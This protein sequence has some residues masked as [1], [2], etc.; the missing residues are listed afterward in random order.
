MID[1]HNHILPGI[2]DGAKTI[3]D[4]FA[5]LKEAKEAGFTKIIFTPHY[6]E[7]FYEVE[8]PEKIAL[9][10]EIKAQFA[11]IEPEME[12][13]LANEIYMSGDNIIEYLEQAKASTINNTRYVLFELPM[14][15]KP[16]NLF[17]MV[18]EIQRAKLIPVL[19]HPE[20]YSFVQNNPDL[21]YDLIERGI[22]MQ[23]NYASILGRYGKKAQVIAKKML[24]ANAVHFLGSDVHMVN[25]IYKNM[26]KSIEKIK[27][28]I[29]EE[30]FE[31][32]SKINPTK[33]LKNQKIDI[34][35]PGKIKLNIVEKMQMNAK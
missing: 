32:L 14:N 1:F 17:D 21:I 6:K 24:Q 7:E 25:T 16:L 2:D 28:I 18:Y 15:S 30:K 29:G 13:Y 33:V 23:Q 4:T 31:E 26:Q 22:L 9:F 27:D 19:A 35:M 20:R 12:L 34:S 8:V 10:N 11:R 3:E 5:L